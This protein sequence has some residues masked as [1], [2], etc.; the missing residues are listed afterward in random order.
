LIK[1]MF[2]CHGNICRSPMAEMITKHLLKKAGKQGEVLVSSSAVSPE[3]Y[4]NP[5]YPP[6]KRALAA[7]GVATDKEKRAVLFT[8]RD[9]NEYDL[10]YVMDS[11]NLRRVLSITD[12]D[13]QNKVQKLLKAVGMGEDVDDPWYYGGFD[14]VC[15]QIYDACQRLLEDLEI[16]VAK[17]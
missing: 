17:K 9:Y 4:D 10:I 2:V 8:A 14:G 13:P 1:I 6:A 7:M 11:S 12:N 5:V 3:E 16:L 15:R